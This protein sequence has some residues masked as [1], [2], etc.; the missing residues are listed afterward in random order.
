MPCGACA[1]ARRVLP[2]QAREML[3]RLEKRREEEAKKRA[4]GKTKT[5]DHA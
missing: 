5:P 1:K 4:G 3:E 2:K